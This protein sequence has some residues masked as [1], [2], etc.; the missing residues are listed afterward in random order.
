MVLDLALRRF[1]LL[2]DQR[3]RL[4]RKPRESASPHLE[5]DGAWS[6]I[7]YLSRIDIAGF[8][9]IDLNTVLGFI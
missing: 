5:V 4:N 7:T 9:E 2:V 8:Q 3:K 1:C 6:A